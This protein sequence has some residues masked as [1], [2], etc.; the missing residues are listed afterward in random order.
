[1]PLIPILTIAGTDP[2]GGAGA[3]AD[4]RAIT[5]SGGYGMAAVAAVTVQNTVGVRDT[6]PV[7]P[8][9]VAGQIDAVFDDVPPLAVK[10]GM[11]CNQA[12][13]LAVAEA[14]RRRLG[15]VPYVCD[16]VMVS[17]SGY[18]LLDDKAVDAMVEG[19]FPQA[20]LVTPNRNEA[21]RLTGV[22]DPMHQI[23]ILREMGCRNILVKGG[24]SARK[25]VKIDYLSI[26]GQPVEPLVGEAVATRNTHGTGCTMSAVVATL[27]ASGVELPQAVRRAKEFIGRALRAGAATRVGAGHGPCFFQT[28]N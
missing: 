3:L 17:T 21:Y 20:A 8:A 12:I 2:T 6:L 11:L 27:L 28:E 26:Q 14:L 9:V 5:A 1:M 18:H 4:L 25:D 13:V 10:S 7:P 22:E 15:A 19:L 24:D 23:D 16:P